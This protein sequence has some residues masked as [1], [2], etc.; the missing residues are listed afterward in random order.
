M[1]DD[2]DDD[3]ETVDDLMDAITAFEC[4]SAVLERLVRWT[5]DKEDL[6]QTFEHCTA[7]CWYWGA[8]SMEMMNRFDVAVPLLKVYYERFVYYLT[9]FIRKCLNAMC[10][11]YKRLIVSSKHIAD[12]V[13]LLRQG[14]ILHELVRHGYVLPRPVACTSG[15]GQFGHVLPSPDI[16]MSTFVVSRVPHIHE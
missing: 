11:Y 10:S 7:M 12:N 8:D 14:D 4:I 16:L 5:G 15:F 2:D 1:T 13:T 3:D 6:M 9:E